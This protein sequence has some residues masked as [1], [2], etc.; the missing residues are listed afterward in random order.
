MIRALAIACLS[1]VGCSTNP[2]FLAWSSNEKNACLP[3][4]AVMVQGLCKAEI[5]AKVLI[6]TTPEFRHAVAVYLYPPGSNQMWAWDAN[7]K[8]LRLRAY[9]TDADQCAR[10]WLT[11]TAHFI[12]LTSAEFLSAE[13]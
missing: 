5:Q 2:P 12:P 3:E 9:W 7:W 1:L 6:I 4:A 11:T 8:S 13:H 10:A